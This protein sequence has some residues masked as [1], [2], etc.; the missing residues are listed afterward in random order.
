MKIY[1]LQI[2]YF[3]TDV[4]EPS[5]DYK[6]VINICSPLNY[7]ITDSNRF[8]GKLYKKPEKTYYEWARGNYKYTDDGHFNL[9]SN[10]YVS[11]FTYFT[12]C[13]ML[14]IN[15]QKAV[16]NLQPFK[17][18]AFDICCKKLSEYC[19]KNDISQI[20][21]II[22][23]KDILEGNWDKILGIIQK[24]CDWMDLYIYQ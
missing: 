23:G 16:D 19:K 22:F 5:A 3:I 21:T 8:L 4:E 20:R 17:Y 12:I 13:N 24:N 15:R 7:G 14:C 9:G 1:N 2:K 10:Q 11:I 18:D 6:I